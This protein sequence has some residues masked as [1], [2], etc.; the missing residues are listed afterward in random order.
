MPE[1]YA[2]QAIQAVL[3][4]QRAYCKFLAANDTGLTG[5]HQAGI[6]IS[7]PSIPILFDEPGIK[8]TNKEKWVK[9]KWQDGIETDTRFIYYGKGTRNE[10]RIT[11]FGRGFPFLRPEYTGALFVFTKCDAEDYQAFVLN[12]EE[13]ID[14]FLD[15]F[16]ISPTETNQ[17]IDAG[18]VQE[19]TQERIAIQEFI[20]GL[21]VDFPLSEE[22][23]AAARDIQNRVYDHLE[24]IRTNP[25]RKII[26]WTNTEY[27]LFRAIE[28]ARYGDAIA[29]GFTSVDEFITMANM[30]LNRRK[31]RAGK[32]LEHH[33]SAI[34]DG[35]EIIYTAQAVTEGNKKPDFIFP[36]QASYHDMTFPTERL[37]SRLQKRPARI[38][39]VR[40][41]MKPTVCVTGPNI[42]V[43]SSRESPL[44]R[45]TKCRAR[46]LFLLFPDN[47]LHPIPQIVRTEYGRFQS[48]FLMCA[49]SKDSDGGY[50]FSGKTQSEYVCDTIKKHKA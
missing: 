26:D 14:Q 27:A 23:S 50:C 38:V 22:M 5:G 29:R 35:N 19:E 8:G 44:H 10:Y 3:S 30:V 36:S 46:M 49:R 41:S 47:T 32:S 4:G 31:S 34:F 1:G 2:I 9:V 16:G 28:H 37:I 39:G 18:R 48:S 12:S 43:R 6:Y 11:N 20:A 33:L 42:S 21:T 24:F 13:D 7:K 40:L 17:L 45:W 25:D 15:A